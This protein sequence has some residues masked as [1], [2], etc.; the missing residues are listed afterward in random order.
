MNKKVKIWI[1]NHQIEAFFVLALAICYV[2]LFPAIY[3]IPNDAGLGGVSRFYLGKIGVYSPVIAGI[4]ITRIILPGKHQT[5]FIRRLKTSLP[6]WFIAVV[7]SIASLKLTVPPSVPMRG[8]IILSIPVALL[9]AW[10]VSSA[11]SGSDSIRNML[12]TLIKP[13]GEVFYY[14]FAL[15]TFPVVMLVGSIITNI[16][17]GNPWFPQINQVDNLLVVVLINFFFVIFFA[18]GIDEEAG[19]RGFAQKRLQAKHSPLITAIVLWFY[20]IIWHIPNDLIQYQNGGYI[21]VRIVLYLFIMILFTWTYNRTKGSI[22]A[23]VIFHASMNSMNPLMGI[24]PITTAS[25]VLLI[26]LA[27][28]I[29]ILG[30]MWRKLPENHPAVYQD[31]ALSVSTEKG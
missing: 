19:W 22:L 1:K 6:V 28:T 14:L 17:A 11:F 7:V 27:I 23:I 18:G 8:L 9:P 16:I 10:V 15:L 29:L 5:S 21:M 25:N 24:F 20:L 3:L 30:R 4:F 12:K 31:A 26:A 2:T 13:S